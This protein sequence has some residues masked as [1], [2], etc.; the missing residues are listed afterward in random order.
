MQENGAAANC[1]APRHCRVDPDRPAGESS[2]KSHRLA[3]C[4]RAHP[5]AAVAENQL[6]QRWR[7]YLPTP[8]WATA[9]FIDH[10]GIKCLAHAGSCR[11]SHLLAADAENIPLASVALEPPDT[12]VGN[13]AR[14]APVHRGA[15]ALPWSQSSCSRHELTDPQR[16]AA[17]VSDH[18]CDPPLPS[19]LPSSLPSLPSSSSSPF[20]PSIKA[21]S[22]AAASLITSPRSCCWASPMPCHPRLVLLPS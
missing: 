19:S 4:R 9:P 5:L 7:G 11:R 13:R 18:S 15:H 10:W 22:A 14:P 1:A 16:L 6:R 20:R 2:P 8:T 17:F 3:G 21:N 12:T